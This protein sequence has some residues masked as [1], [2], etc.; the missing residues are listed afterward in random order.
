M[1]LDIIT[2]TD[3]KQAMHCGFEPAVNLSWAMR[4]YNQTVMFFEALL[5]SQTHPLLALVQHDLVVPMEL[6]ASLAPT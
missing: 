6:Q 5:A 1:S 3:T 2:A 4:I